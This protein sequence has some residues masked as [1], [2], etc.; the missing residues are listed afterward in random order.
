MNCSPKNGQLTE[1]QHFNHEDKIGK[2]HGLLEFYK[3]Q[4]A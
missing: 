4:D 2:N 3:P 1:K